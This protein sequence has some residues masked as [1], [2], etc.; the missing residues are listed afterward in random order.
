MMADGHLGCQAFVLCSLIFTRCLSQRAVLWGYESF[1]RV[2]PFQAT[3]R[4]KS[5][6]LTFH[7]H[8][9]LPSMNPHTAFL[10]SS[11]WAELSFLLIPNHKGSWKS[12][13]CFLSQ[14]C[15]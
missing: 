3:E 12:F 8:S 2:I 4:S 9:N 7:A 1:N 6:S 5:L 14:K 10:L 11:Q 15:A 13:V